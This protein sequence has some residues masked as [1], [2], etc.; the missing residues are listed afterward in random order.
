MQA[1][2]NKIDSLTANLDKM[3][4]DRLSGLL[5]EADFERIYSK[6]KLERS[7]LEEKRKELELRKKSPVRTEDRAKEL[8]QRFVDSAFTSRELLVSL[9]ERV[10]LTEDKQ[11]IIRFRFQQLNDVNST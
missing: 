10:E 4:M 6:V 11:I 8:V 7:L 2:Q 1:I 5:A 3:Y 9:I